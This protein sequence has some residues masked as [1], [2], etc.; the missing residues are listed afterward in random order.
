MAVSV[1][2]AH[3]TVIPDDAA[4]DVGAD[5]W[6]AAHTITA[7]DGKLLGASGSTTVG[8]V[9]VG[10]GLSLAAGTLSCTV[11][12]TG[13]SNV[14][15]DT[16]PQ[17]GGGLD[18]NTF[19]VTGTG[20]INITGAITASTTVTGADVTA[21]DDIQVGD[22]LLFPNSGSVIDFGAG[23]VTITYTANALTVAGGNFFI[24]DEAYDASAWNGNLSIPTKNA[25][26]DYLETLTGTTLPAT[27][28]PLDGDLTSWAGVTRAAGFD[29]F[30]A[31]PTAANFASLVT[32]ESYG[33]TD[34]ELAAL[35]GLTSAADKVPYFTGSGTAALA[36][37]SSAMRTFMTTSSSANLKS[38]VSDET[39]SGGALV[40]ATAPTISTPNIDTINLT[41]G[42]IAFPSTQAASAGA[43]TLDDYEEGT[44]TTTIITSGTAPTTLTY[45]TQ[46]GIYTKVGRMV[47]VS[48]GA[49]IN[50]FTLGAGTGNISLTTLPFASSSASTAV[51]ACYTIGVDWPAASYVI[52]YVG[53]SAT[54]VVPYSITD[55]AGATQLTLA[56]LA[57]TDQI[58]CSGSYEV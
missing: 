7:T 50:A 40:F 2:H 35:A 29:T 57:A 26:R 47:N 46:L 44:F 49:I 16:T 52:G 12:D 31:S 13:I 15:E 48:I 45:T 20:N 24:V 32:G 14:V 42:Q 8:E 23:D 33:L 41:G 39:G 22:D 5:E 18:L 10:T 3:Q 6:N 4:Y 27:Y 9:T 37:L 55:N 51:L 21:S 36:D 17:L 11:T 19:D 1:T 34:A 58:F 56:G 28:Q 25:V 30:V 53:G 38:L 54:T 43:N